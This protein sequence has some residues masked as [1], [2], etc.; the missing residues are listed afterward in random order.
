MTCH[1][2]EPVVVLLWVYNYVQEAESLLLVHIHDSS[3]WDILKN[4][5]TEMIIIHLA[6]VPSRSV[7][8]HLARTLIDGRLYPSHIQIPNQLT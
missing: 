8:Q 3:A 6:W 4:G 2:V 5:A 7:F 1:N